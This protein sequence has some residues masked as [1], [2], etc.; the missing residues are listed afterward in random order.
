[1]AFFRIFFS[2]PGSIRKQKSSF[3]IQEKKESFQ[4]REKNTVRD[5][6]ERGRD[7]ERDLFGNSG[8]YKTILSNK[9]LND[10]CPQC[11]GMITRQAFLGGNIYFCPV[12]QPLKNS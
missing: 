3:L 1:M 4:K 2:T 9:T 11:G 6:P 7:T 5:G 8:S 12:C 10:P